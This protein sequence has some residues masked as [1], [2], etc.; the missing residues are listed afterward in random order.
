MQDF[1]SEPGFTSSGTHLPLIGSAR[2]YFCD[3][4]AW[5]VAKARANNISLGLMD[6]L[7]KSRCPGNFFQLNASEWGAVE[8]E[9]HH[10][11]RKLMS[12]S[13]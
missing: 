1:L 11:G 8:Q 3:P 9:Y 10:Q 13:R 7:A 4:L 6:A 2:A 5:D 12:C